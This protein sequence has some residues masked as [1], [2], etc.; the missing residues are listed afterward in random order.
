MTG[1]GSFSSGTA[2]IGSP[3]PIS[4]HSRPTTNVSAIPVA[5]LEDLLTGAL[6]ED[7]DAADGR[8][9]SS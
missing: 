8:G 5:H 1:Q 7:E 6:E 4:S 9:D 2:T 3:N